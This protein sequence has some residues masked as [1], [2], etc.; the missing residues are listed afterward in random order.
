MSKNKRI[1]ITLFEQAPKFINTVGAGFGFTANALVILD[2][3]GLK[4]KL[5]KFLHPILSH[6]VIGRNGNLIYNGNA[7]ANLSR[8]YGYNAM[9]GTLRAD[10][11]NVLKSSFHENNTNNPIL[12]DSKVIVLPSVI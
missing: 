8:K 2:K 3:L 7:L 1:S 11:V 5:N 9:S 6:K 12:F 4:K 10:L